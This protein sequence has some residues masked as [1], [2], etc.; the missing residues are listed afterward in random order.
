MSFYDW[1]HVKQPFGNAISF[2]LSQHGDLYAGWSNGSIMKLPQGSHTLEL[3]VSGSE[4]LPTAGLKRITPRSHFKFVQPEGI[5]AWSVSHSQY[6]GDSQLNRIFK[7]YGGV[8]ALIAGTGAKGRKDGDG[9]TEASFEAIRSIAVLPKYVVVLETP[10]VGCSIRLV[11]QTTHRV[12]TLSSY[13]QSTPGTS[14]FLNASQSIKLDS[15][16][17]ALLPQLR[18]LILPTYETNIAETTVENIS[19]SNEVDDQ[20]IALAKY[21]GSNCIYLNGNPAHLHSITSA[22]FGYCLPAYCPLEDSLFAIVGGNLR[23]LKDFCKGKRPSSASV[24]KFEDASILL[25][26]SGLKSDLEIT[27]E[28]SNTTFRLLRSVIDRDVHTKSNSVTER[29]EI[30]VRTSTLPVATI[31]R[32]IEHLY[33]KP[34]KKV[35]CQQLITFA[36]IYKLVFRKEDPIILKALQDQIAHESESE[37]HELLISCWMNH[38]GPFDLDESSLIVASMLPRV[39]QNRSGFKLAIDAFISQQA[40]TLH[41]IL[42]RMTSLL[43]LVV[44]PSVNATLPDIET[45]SHNRFDPC[46][47]TLTTDEFLDLYPTNFVIEL[48]SFNAFRVCGWLLYIH[49]PWFKRLIDSG[50]RES[51]TR[52]ITLPANSLTG[53]AAHYLLGKLQFGQMDLFDRLAD[54]DIISI[55]D[56][57]AAFEL[58]DTDGNALPRVKPLINACEARANRLLTPLNCW[59]HLRSS[60]PAGSCMYRITLDFILEA[61]EKAPLAEL[62]TLPDEAVLDLMHKM[63]LRSKVSNGL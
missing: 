48:P 45:I 17:I 10:Y 31:T 62:S 55:L 37:I 33:F 19:L 60:H 32:F 58:I 28:A 27:H 30:F 49:W 7:I 53:P 23:I 63:K 59:D 1:I 24:I 14:F 3:Y 22:H 61:V 6:V 5:D 39:Q 40:S 56:H 57:A 47:L 38:F 26:P 15:V 51:K 4:S 29:L 2:S 11:D 8:V 43:S 46:N 18:T 50:L 54:R 35:D 36:G 41:L 25:A 42:S 44:G 21:P 16:C 34:L 20:H 9:L 13:L 12:K 52:T